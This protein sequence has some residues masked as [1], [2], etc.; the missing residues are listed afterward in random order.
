MTAEYICL[1]G[2]SRPIPGMKAGDTDDTCSKD[3]SMVVATGQGDK[4]FWFLFGKMPRVYQ[5]HEIPRSSAQDATKFVQQHGD[6]VVRPDGAIK[7]ATLWQ[8]REVTTL[9]AFE[10]ADLAHWTTGRI[11][12]LGDSVHNMTPHWD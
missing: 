5:S 8:A 1:F 3:V 7:L 6:M 9:C 4:V 10:E 11:V 2:V 12:C